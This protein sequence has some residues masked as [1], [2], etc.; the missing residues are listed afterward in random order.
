MS[1][2]LLDEKVEVK[3]T[4]HLA[5]LYK[6]ILFNDDNHSMEEVVA[7]I[8]CAI[9]CTPEEATRI[10]LEAHNSGR[11]IVITANY[12]RCEHVESILSEIRLGTKIEP[13]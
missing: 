10:M 5:K 12:E 7:Q 11:A 6:V 3:D 1:N 2:T 8:I 13:A 4:T 9:H